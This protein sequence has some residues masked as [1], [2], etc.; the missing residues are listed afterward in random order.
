MQERYGISVNADG[1][2]ITLTGNDHL[3]FNEKGE[4]QKTVGIFHWG[5]GVIRM[6]PLPDGRAISCTRGR[7]RR[8]YD[9]SRRFYAG[10]HHLRRKGR[11]GIAR[12]HELVEPA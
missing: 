4:R 9:A 8:R 7:G 11:Q 12:R 3:V 1:S 6:V 5:T 2:R 10:Q